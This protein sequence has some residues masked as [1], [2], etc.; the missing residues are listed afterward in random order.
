MLPPQLKEEIVREHER[1]CLVHKQFMALEARSKAELRTAASG[2]TAAK[3]NQLID[4]KGI[5]AVSGRELMNEAFY[6]PFDNRRQV[7]SYFC[8]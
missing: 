4:L 1:L 2:S 8:R 3:I 6:R 7:G 5:G